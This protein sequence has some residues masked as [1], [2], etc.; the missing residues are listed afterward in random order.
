MRL[1]CGSSVL[2]LDSP[3]VMG[4]LNVTPD[5]FSDGGIYLDVEKAIA[6]GKAMLEQ[7][8]RIIDVGGESTR[9]GA[10][11]VDAAEE[12]RRVLPVVTALANVGATVSIDT[13]KPEVILAAVK[14]GAALIND[15]RAL[16]EPRALKA[17]AATH[18]A[19]CLMHMRGEPATMQQQPQYLDVVGEVRE[20]LGERMRACIAAGIDASRLAIDPGIGFGKSVE[21]NLSLLARLPELSTLGRPVLIG[22]SRKSTIGVLTGRDVDRRLPGGLAFATAAVL[23]GAHI[24]RAH[25]VA[26]T[27]DAVKVATALRDRGYKALRGANAEC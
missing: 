21:H 26:A 17:A 13:S 6:Y 4:V 2:D 12:I 23:A 10:A 19:I 11:T 16:R 8:A 7:G 5:S 20:F 18:A 3:C 15:V 22:V 25:D 14:A 9:P 24:I 1:H 27:V